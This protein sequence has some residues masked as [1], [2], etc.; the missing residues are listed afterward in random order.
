MNDPR[1]PTARFQLA[2]E[3]LADGDR[4]VPSARA[5]DRD[6]YVAPVLPA[7]PGEQEEDQVGE[8]F[9]HFFIVRL[10]QEVL[11][12]RFVLP[13]LLPQTRDEMRVREE[14]HVEEQVRSIRDAVLE[15]E[16]YQGDY[17]SGLLARIGGELPVDLAADLVHRAGGGVED[18][19]GPAA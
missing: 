3:Q 5:A 2:P 15:A 13:R 8:T 4:A 7:V 11:L 18:H 19:L 9:H 1:R 10:A 12:H 14:P 16:A 17:H 6:R